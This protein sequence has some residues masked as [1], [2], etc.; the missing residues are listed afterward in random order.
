LQLKSE[1]VVKAFIDR[2]REVNPHINA[3][4]QDNYDKAIQEAKQVDR[5][6]RKVLDGELAPESLDSQPFLGVPFTCKDSI[7]VKDVYW[8]SGLYTRKGITA[9]DDS[10][11]I[12]RMR[13]SGAIFIAMTNIP[14]L[15]MW[16]DSYNKLYGRTYNPYDKSRISGGS[17]GGE[18]ALISAAGS[19]IGVCFC[20]DL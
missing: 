5:Q 9:T 12:T 17:S 18:A 8:T 6:V 7:A 19:V 3:I 20:N 1:E 13:K 11:V 2:C 15:G 14:E 10:E 4:I 16:W